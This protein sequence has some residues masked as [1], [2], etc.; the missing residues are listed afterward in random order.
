MRVNYS[1][2]QW[3]LYAPSLWI[4]VSHLTAL[5]ETPQRR[6]CSLSKSWDRLCTIYPN[7]TKLPAFARS[8]FLH[9]Q[10]SQIRFCVGAKA[11]LLSCT[12]L[13]STSNLRF[14]IVTTS[15]FFKCCKSTLLT[16]PDFSTL[17]RPLIWTPEGPLKALGRQ[18]VLTIWYQGCLLTSASYAT[19]RNLYLI[20]TLWEG[21][22]L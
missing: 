7:P 4:P 10:L 1:I 13:E 15:F 8:F 12:I 11:S 22:A 20:C 17:F 19:H 14:P 9:S 3:T 18:H 5:L 2:I 21:T 6:L 16:K